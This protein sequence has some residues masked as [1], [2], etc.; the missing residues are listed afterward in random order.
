MEKTIASGALEALL[1]I[2]GEPIDIKKAAK[3][4]D[5]EPA[6][7]KAA[8]QQLQTRLASE[9]SGLAL[10]EHEGALQL[11]TRSE[12]GGL[13][14]TVLKAELHEALSSASLETLSIITYAGPVS[15]AEIDYIRGVNSSFTLRALLLR[16]LIARENDP[17]RAN[18]YRYSPSVE[19]LRHLGI[20]TAADLPEYERFRTLVTAMR[21]PAPAPAEKPTQPGNE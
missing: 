2:Y 20:T 11:T 19:L 4:L 16:G 6:A 3:M 21:A 9:Q 13:L 17:A 8:A 14:Q 12:F 15:R 1:F 5:V 10:L 7:V 18:A